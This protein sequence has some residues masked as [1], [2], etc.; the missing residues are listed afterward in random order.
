MTE[1][2]AADGLC[3][4]LYMT[5]TGQTDMTEW[6]EWGFDTKPFDG[7]QV[8]YAMILED[9]LA[10]QDAQMSCY[11]SY[12]D[13]W[14]YFC[15]GVFGS[16]ANEGEYSIH[17][18]GY[19]YYTEEE[20]AEI[21]AYEAAMEEGEGEYEEYEE[22]YGDYAEYEYEE[23]A[24][25]YDAEA[26][27]ID[28]AMAGNPM[29]DDDLAWYEPASWCEP[30]FDEYYGEYGS[31]CVVGE[32]GTFIGSWFQPKESDSYEQNFRL[33]GGMSGWSWCIDGANEADSG[34]FIGEWGAMDGA[35]ALSAGATILAVASLI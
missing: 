26:A 11:G 3:N 15:T 30:V 23:Y 33:T 21:A 29:D 27:F 5:I 17:G 25:Y 32:D 7:Y 9:P 19:W 2:T 31:E 4:G 14:G 18:T 35:A 10:A 34:D 8:G 1:I 24:E 28:W 6:A 12:D 16:E 13:A 20:L 22:Y